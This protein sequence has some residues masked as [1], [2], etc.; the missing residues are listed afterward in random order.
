MLFLCK[1]VVHVPSKPRK[2]VLDSLEAGSSSN[3][4]LEESLK[5]VRDP[6]LLQDELHDGLLLLHKGFKFFGL[7]NEIII[8]NLPSDGFGSHCLL[9]QRDKN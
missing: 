3:T 4:G 6:Q 1:T 9:T 8:G 2:A 5:L 7:L